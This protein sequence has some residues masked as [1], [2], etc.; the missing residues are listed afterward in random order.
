MAQVNVAVFWHQFFYWCSLRDCICPNTNFFSFANSYG[1]PDGSDSSSESWLNQKTADSQRWEAAEFF[2]ITFLLEKADGLLLLAALCCERVRAGIFFP[3]ENKK[4][5]PFS[6][7]KKVRIFLIWWRRWESNYFPK[8]KRQKTNLLSQNLTLD[9]WVKTGESPQNAPWKRE[10]AVKSAVN[11]H[12]LSISANLRLPQVT[13]TNFKKSGHFG[14]GN[15]VKPS[16]AIPVSQEKLLW[17]FT[18]QWVPIHQ[19]ALCTVVVF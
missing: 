16:A 12:R 13:N 7:R 4:S 9:R 5:E 11:F 14:V 1:L 2:T 17:Y 15:A 3:K 6:H 18:K 10:S 19:I 8:G